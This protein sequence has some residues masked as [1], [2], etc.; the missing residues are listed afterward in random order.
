MLLWGIPHGIWNG[1]LAVAKL[2]GN[3]RAFVFVAGKLAEER[4]GVTIKDF[5]NFKKTSLS[6]LAVEM[7]TI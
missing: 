2:D 5:Y 7:W 3:R 4:L 6:R 1:L